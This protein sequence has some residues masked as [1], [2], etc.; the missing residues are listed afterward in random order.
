MIQNIGFIGLG[1]MGGRMAKNAIKAG[2]PLTVFDKRAEVLAEFAALGALIAKTPRDVG[3]A[4]DIVV[5][6]VMNYPQTEEVL[7]GAD[8]AAEGLAKGAIVACMNTISHSEI[9]AI[10]GKL[11]ERGVRTLDAPV[12]GGAPAAEVG[13]LTI[14]A[15]ASPDVMDD[16]RPFLN[17]VG[18]KIFHCGGVGTGQTLK[19]MNQLLCSVEM[20]SIAEALVLGAKAGVDGQTL[21]EVTSA[22]SGNSEMFRRKVPKIIA[23]DFSSFGDLD[24]HVKDL[25]IVTRAAKEL[26]VPMF[27]TN[28]AQEMYRMAQAMGKGK[29]DGCAVITVLED[30]TGAKPRRT[31]IEEGSSPPVMG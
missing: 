3:K 14:M 31:G 11:A 16:A 17:A 2:F 27:V 18:E 1:H 19:M 8:G 26:G 10:A 6:M 20:V 12:S 21:F 7:F 25:E 15:G 30:A 23:G 4:S 29:L 13:K 28:A 5:I 9:K 24:I 22:G